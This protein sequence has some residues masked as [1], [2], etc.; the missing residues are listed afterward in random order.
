MIVNKRSDKENIKIYSNE[1]P[2]KVIKYTLLEKPKSR[3]VCR[4]ES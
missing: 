1:K 2:I 4:S 3:I